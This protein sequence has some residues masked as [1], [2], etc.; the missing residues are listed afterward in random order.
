MEKTIAKKGFP[1]IHV[2][3]SQ[4]MIISMA[5][6]F[7]LNV[8]SKRNGVMNKSI[9]SK[10]VFINIMSLCILI[11]PAPADLMKID[12]S[13][14]LSIPT[15]SQ[16]VESRKKSYW[17][18]GLSLQDP[19]ISDIFGYK[20]FSK[21]I[22]FDKELITIFSYALCTTIDDDSEM[23]TLLHDRTTFYSPII[24]IEDSSFGGTN[25]VISYDFSSMIGKMSPQ[26]SAVWH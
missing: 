15:Y 13:F 20:V 2:K 25:S 14:G 21:S 4:V 11:Q 6:A 1:P 19:D 24:E 3:R 12:F 17:L 9:R 16:P 26:I 22:T 7:M 10:W 5:G 23:F 18:S 8:L